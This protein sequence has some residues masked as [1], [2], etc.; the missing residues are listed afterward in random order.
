MRADLHDDP[1]MYGIEVID[2]ST[3]DSSQGKEKSIIL[4]HFVATRLG[5]NPRG[6]FGFIKNHGRLNV[7]ITRARDFMFMVGNFPLWEHWM[8]RNF[9]R[10]SGSVAR[11]PFEAIFTIIDYMKMNDLVVDF[12]IFARLKLTGAK[13]SQAR[14]HS[15]QM[16]IADSFSLATATR[17]TRHYLFVS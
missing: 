8:Q 3:V 5:T 16:K 15:S 17:P 7:A 11:K 9:Y 12:A 10:L 2:V 13:K 14:P 4:L 6:P 1:D